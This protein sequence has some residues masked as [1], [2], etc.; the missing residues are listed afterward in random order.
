V[1]GRI[2]GKRE[3]THVVMGIDLV[4]CIEEAVPMYEEALLSR[5]LKKFHVCFSVKV[6]EVEHGSE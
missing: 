4:F 3:M 1:P 2:M 5:I 6:L